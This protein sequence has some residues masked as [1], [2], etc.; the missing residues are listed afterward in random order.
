MEN[1]MTMKEPLDSC[2]WPGCEEQVPIYWWGCDRH[3]FALPLEH[4]R[5]IWRTFRPYA[6]KHSNEYLCAHWQAEVWIQE[7]QA[8]RK[9]PT[10]TD[11]LNQA[12]KGG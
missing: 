4:R 12:R 11:P 9:R 2:Q 3:W 8:R 10:S 7:R 5:E 1:P 6:E